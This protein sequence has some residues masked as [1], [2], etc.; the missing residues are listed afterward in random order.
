MEI[1]NFAIFNKTRNKVLG[2]YITPDSKLGLR[3]VSCSLTH[4]P[5]ADIFPWT[6]NCRR[7]AEQAMKQT[8][9][10]SMS[11]LDVPVNPYFEKGDVLEIREVK[12]QL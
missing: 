12:I 7:I 9:E 4:L 5:D 3:Q 2:A 8:I 11:S 6:V 10:L 1:T